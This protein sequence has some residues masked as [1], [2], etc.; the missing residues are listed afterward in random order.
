[1][2]QQ[3]TKFT[4]EYPDGWNGYTHLDWNATEKCYHP[5]DDYNFGYG[6]DDLGQD[7]VA[8]YD[9][10]VIHTSKSTSGYG[11]IVVLK[12]TL[13]YNLK[14][15]I[16]D[17]YGIDTSE[18]YSLYAHLKDIAVKAGDTLKT[19]ERVGSVGNSGTVWA[20]LHFEIY[21]PIGELAKKGW[22]FWPSTWSKEQIQQYWIPA[23]L[24][25]ESTKN[26]EGT[27][28]FLGKP[29]DYW[30]TVER[31][32]ENLL[33]Q[34]GEKDKQWALKLEGVTKEYQHSIEES[35]KKATTAEEALETAKKDLSKL[36]EK[37]T[38]A[39]T[40]IT[41]LKT[42]NSRLLEQLGEKLSFTEAL[43]I[44]LSKLIPR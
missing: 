2:W 7:A 24:F 25:I 37:L 15:Y 39:E 38:K 21:A 13:G 9:A 8:C 42:Q 11:N 30:L 18:L 26:T 5:G 34:L 6:N 23:Y 33:Q 41:N 17:T 35:A 44:V 43:R 40:E 19:G 3:P 31:D 10:T 4:N 36:E 28:T 16:K 1:M 14:R 32:R 22:R 27:E 29:K 12:H 20:H